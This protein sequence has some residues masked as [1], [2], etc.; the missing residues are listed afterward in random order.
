MLNDNNFVS[1]NPEH[2]AASSYDENL[3]AAMESEV[4][5][6]G[7][8]HV[9]NHNRKKLLIRKRYAMRQEENYCE[10]FCGLLRGIRD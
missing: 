3:P 10:D 5:I 7:K 9:N 6:N 8:I 4:Y 2:V 1:D